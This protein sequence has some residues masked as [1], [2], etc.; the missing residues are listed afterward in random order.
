MSIVHDIV[1]TTVY[2]YSEPVEFGVHRVMFRPRDSHDQRVLAT[3]L[4]VSPQSDIRLIQD[5]YSN[6]IALV[7]PIGPASELRFTCAFAID[8]VPAE[9][10]PPVAPS[11]EFLPFTYSPDERIDL[12]H[13]LRPHYDDPHG[14]L[15]AWVHQFLAEGSRVA[16]LELLAR[17]N[18][19]IGQ[20]LT[21][22]ARD[23]EGTQTPVRTLEL[24]SGSCRDYALLM[25]EAVRRLGL[26]ARFVSGYLYDESL[27]ADGKVAMVG[28]GSTHAW[29]QVFLPGTGWITYDPTN[30]LIGDS[31]L[32]R[33]AVVRDPALASPISGSW[34]GAT[35]AFLGMTTQVQVRRRN[36]DGLA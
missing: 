16:T 23:E 26:A 1:H 8:H 28:A 4:Q 31:R 35:Q 24:G 15:I 20:N 30:N 6:S 27:D 17:I 25:M 9:A 11:A 10:A 36:K 2:N 7:Q 21:Y 13:Y 14:T 29:M 33:V 3:D 18:A 5:T 12:E 19:Y 32:I 22:A 34:F